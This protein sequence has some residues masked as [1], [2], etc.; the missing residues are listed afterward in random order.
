MDRLTWFLVLFP[1]IPQFLRAVFCSIL[2]SGVQFYGFILST[3]QIAGN[4]KLICVHTWKIHV[5]LCVFEYR[6]S[7]VVFDHSYVANIF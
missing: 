6:P 7:R 5:C 2:D 1:A 3:T 4:G